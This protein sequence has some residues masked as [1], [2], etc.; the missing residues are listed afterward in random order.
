MEYDQQQDVVYGYKDGMALVMDV[1]T[2]KVSPNGVG[3]IWVAAGYWQEF[4]AWRRDAFALEAGE[5][6]PSH[7]AIAELLRPLL[8]AGFS[9]FAVQHSSQPRYTIDDIRPDMSR[10][11]RYIRHHA[12]DFDIH[13]Q[14]IG[15]IGGS[16]GGHVSLMAATAPPPPDTDGEDPIDRES[17]EIQAVVAYFPPTDF[18][19][20]GSDNTTA[21]DA[22]REFKA[23]EGA[24]SIY[25]AVYDFRRWDAEQQR[26]ER[27]TD[28]TE[29]IEY[30]RR[31]S[32][33]E[34]LS[35]STPPTLLLHGDQDQLVP[36]Q[37]SER[38]VARM[39]KL[40]ITYKFVLFPGLGHAW[41]EPPNNGQ[42]ELLHWFEKY[43][44]D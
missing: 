24:P 11:V 34:H 6:D 37:Q 4:F 41:P 14:R 20:W 39:E 31:N 5:D 7:P 33:I 17:S 10:A 13:P 40:G 1:Y 27:I 43:L 29:R 18:L 26:F 35:V 28:P 3:I 19:N 15:I 16:S 32:P 36:L 12:K 21:Y 38:L 2:P 30:L 44:L 42:E 8:S 22:N 23:R 25:E 9:L